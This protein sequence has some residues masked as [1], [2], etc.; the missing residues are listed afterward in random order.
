MPDRYYVCGQNG[1]G[2]PNSGAVDHEGIPLL[3]GDPLRPEAA[4]ESGSRMVVGIQECLS[5]MLG[6][7]APRWI[8]Y[9]DDPDGSWHAQH[10]YDKDTNPLGFEWVEVWEDGKVDVHGPK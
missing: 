8:V 6:V 4:D 2:R 1:T 3:D 5:W 7:Y 10:A 9:V